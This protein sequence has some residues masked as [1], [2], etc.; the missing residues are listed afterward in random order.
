MDINTGRPA[1]A[2]LPQ[3]R[4][5]ADVPDI[6]GMKLA[7]RTMLADLR[8]TAAVAAQISAGR[9]RPTP[10]RVRALARYLNLLADSIHHHHAAEDD[11]L[12]PVIEKRAGAHIDLTGL[13]DDHSVLDPKLARL[14]SAAAALLAE[15]RSEDAA[16]S[17]ALQ[18]A[19]LRDL[20]EEHIAEEER[21]VFPVILNYLTVAD[22]AEVE[23]RIRK[24]GVKLSF[25]LPRVAD[26][27]TAQE[28]AALKAE[29]G[30]AIVLLLK[31][32][33]PRFRRMERAIWG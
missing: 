25:E 28:L 4:A 14:R 1:G 15:P 31:L 16:A 19:Q 24:R 11:I 17:L 22:W 10:A 7:H 23:N 6:I 13:S 26:A 30:V 9:V 2:D 29:A 5:A 20:L 21:D 32:V 18:L 8:R 27:C 33:Q 3:Q 12:W